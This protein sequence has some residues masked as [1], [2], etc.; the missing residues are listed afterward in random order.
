MRAGG[1]GE[2]GRAINRPHLVEFT[3]VLYYTPQINIFPKVKV[4][5][6]KPQVRIVKYVMCIT[7]IK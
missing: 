3:R 7:I 1:Q 5:P 4:D 2:Q 6:V